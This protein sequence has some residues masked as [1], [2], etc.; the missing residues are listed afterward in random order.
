MEPINYL[1]RQGLGR[2][3]ELTR[4]EWLKLG[5]A[6]MGLLAF[7]ELL[8][9]ALLVQAQATASAPVYIDPHTHIFN[10]RDIPVAGF[11]REVA[12]KS[13]LNFIKRLYLRIFLA[14]VLGRYEDELDGA[15]SAR[16]PRCRR[17]PFASHILAAPGASKRT[18]PG[19]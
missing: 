9:A 16:L 7:P 6:G 14:P 18:G 15:A 1:L 19:L 5:L 8:R 11:V 4:R 17:R 10:A 13:K 2:T 3:A 12:V